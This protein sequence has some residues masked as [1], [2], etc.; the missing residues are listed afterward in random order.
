MTTYSMA[1]QPA[2]NASLEK[3]IAAPWLAQMCLSFS[4]IVLPSGAHAQTSA[5]PLPDGVFAQI[6]DERFRFCQGGH[7]RDD[8]RP[9]LC[10]I[11]KPV[12]P[13]VPDVPLESL[14][15]PDRAVGLALAPVLSD[16]IRLRFRTSG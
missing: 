1:A 3:R 12:E 6:N 8:G 2:C 9:A 4:V 15:R 11:D 14:G 10:R 13:Q 5:T 16:R 7:R